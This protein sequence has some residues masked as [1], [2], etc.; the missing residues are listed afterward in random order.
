M[1]QQH[2]KLLIDAYRQRE[3]NTYA[4][5]ERVSDTDLL[6][7]HVPEACMVSSFLPG[8]SVLAR[9]CCSC[10]KQ[11][12]R[13]LLLQS[14]ESTLCT[15]LT[16][17]SKSI[18]LATISTAGWQIRALKIC[19]PGRQQH[20]LCS[21]DDHFDLVYARLWAIIATR[22]QVSGLHWYLTGRKTF[23]C[24]P[25]LWGIIK[26]GMMVIT[27]VKNTCLDP[28]HFATALVLCLKACSTR[29]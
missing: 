5:Q 6:K 28:G 15:M 24:V 2:T 13:Q 8:V 7:V 9:Y 26:S 4:V 16:I 10:T 23:L 11:S 3:C 27:V 21:G 12:E 19:T 25:H 18:C 14:C 1:K 29:L 17:C 20:L 22:N